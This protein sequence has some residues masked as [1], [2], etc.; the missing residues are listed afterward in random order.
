MHPPGRNSNG[1][2]PSGR[3]EHRDRGSGLRG[4]KG[5]PL[6]SRTAN[7]VARIDPSQVGVSDRDPET[8]RL[9]DLED[10]KAGEPV[11]LR[12]LK[13]AGVPVTRDLAR[14]GGHRRRWV[15]HRV[16]TW[17]AVCPRK[18]LHKDG[19]FTDERVVATHIATRSE[20]C[21]LAFPGPALRAR[22]TS[23]CGPH[24]MSGAY[25]GH[26]SAPSL[27]AVAFLL[28]FMAADRCEAERVRRNA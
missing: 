14:R 12:V 7:A 26:T 1:S 28:V 20:S 11:W 10:K 27:G 21:G 9:R 24:G 2:S 8:E 22:G 5:L 6:P 4:A 18:Y 17:Q 3:H 23:A 13:E 16:A 15:G 25:G 19:H